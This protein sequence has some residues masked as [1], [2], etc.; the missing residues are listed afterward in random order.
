MSELK[1]LFYG[2]RNSNW[3]KN[4]S[5]F[6]FFFSNK[7]AKGKNNLRKESIRESIFENEKFSLL[8]FAL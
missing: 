8:N 4:F 6:I 2:E 7:L 3:T 5:L 1:S